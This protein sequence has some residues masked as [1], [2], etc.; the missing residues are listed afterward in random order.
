MELA[1]RNTQLFSEAGVRRILVSSPHCFDTFTKR[2]PNLD[3]EIIHYAVFL[4]R[5]LEEGRLTPSWAVPSVVTYHDPCYLGR[6]NGVFEAP[7]RIL[8]RI[9]GLELVEMPHNREDSLCC[10][11][12]GGGAWSD[13]A[14][15]E[16]FGVV[17]VR[18]AL[19]TGADI[20][21]TAC[22]YCI[23]MLSEAIRCNWVFTDQIVVRDLA[24]LLLQSVTIK[25]D[26]AVPAVVVT[27]GRL[28]RRYCH[29]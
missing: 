26:K 20:I 19:K 16:R 29:V 10:G 28:I 12:G 8:R 24:E 23:R 7:R 5:L 13:L 15:G 25:D 6:H 27:A 18:E 11:G 22:P 9:P 14:P 4:D 3:A 21:T 17:R 2:Y 1:H